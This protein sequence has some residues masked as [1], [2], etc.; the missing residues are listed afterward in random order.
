M[1]LSYS[2]P[3]EIVS[4]SVSEL[5]R[6]CYVP[7]AE[8]VLYDELYRHLLKYIFLEIALDFVLKQHFGVEGQFDE[9]R[10]VFS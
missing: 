6:H 3:V 2:L 10:G 7:A 8:Q 1:V 4:C 5:H 9:G